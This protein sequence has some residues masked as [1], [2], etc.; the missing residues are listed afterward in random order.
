MDWSLFCIWYW[1]LYGHPHYIDECLLGNTSRVLLHNAYP[2]NPCGDDC[3]DGTV[4]KWRYLDNY[5]YSDSLV[6]L[7]KDNFDLLGDTRYYGVESL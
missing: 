4:L 6:I 5:V 1:T 3:S 7:N 2:Y